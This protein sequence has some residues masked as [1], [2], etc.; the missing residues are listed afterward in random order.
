[1]YLNSGEINKYA[2]LTWRKYLV[3]G[4]KYV[5]KLAGSKVMKNI[6]DKY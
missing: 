6:G 1:M 2:A 4:V 5:R 3:G